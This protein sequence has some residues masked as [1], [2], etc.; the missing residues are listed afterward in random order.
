MSSNVGLVD[1]ANG[2]LYGCF[3]VVGF[4]AGS[5]TNAW[6]VKTTL[7]VKYHELLFFFSSLVLTMLALLN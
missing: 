4:L 6:G 1:A 2:A 5:V 7:T 3:A